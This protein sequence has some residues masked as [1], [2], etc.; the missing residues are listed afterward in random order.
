MYYALR[1][2]RTG[3]AGMLI[4]IEGMRAALVFGIGF[5]PILGCGPG[6]GGR[7]SGCGWEVG[8]MGG[9]GRRSVRMMVCVPVRLVV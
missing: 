9:D 5:A 7:R 3:F 6:L 1:E 4:V 8:K 2:R